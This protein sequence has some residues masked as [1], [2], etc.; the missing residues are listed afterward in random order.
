M[1][2]T[3]QIIH[4]EVNDPNTVLLSLPKL[5]DLYLVG[6]G[7]KAIKALELGP[8]EILIVNSVNGVL[9]VETLSWYGQTDAFIGTD[10]N[11]NIALISK[12][13]LDNTLIDLNLVPVDS[14][15]SNL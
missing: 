10:A 14:G 13:V 6:N 12:V 11:G 3:R 2:R 7:N 5:S 1:I 4:A 8:N 15:G 9:T